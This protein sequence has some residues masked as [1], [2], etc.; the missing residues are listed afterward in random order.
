MRGVS[1]SRCVIA[2]REGVLSI[3]KLASGREGY[4]LLAVAHGAEEYYLGG[5]EVPG[6]W[7]GTGATQLDLEGTV[8]DEAFVSLLSGESARWTGAP[9]VGR[10]GGCRPWI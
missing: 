8:T 7:T 5:G 10:T 6:Y 3:G 1:R 4:Y 2:H 9:W